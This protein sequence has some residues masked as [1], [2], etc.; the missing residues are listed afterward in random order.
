MGVSYYCCKSCGRSRYEE[1]VEYCQGCD[2]RICTD[3][4]VDNDGIKSQ[5]AYHYGI[6][7]D[8]TNEEALKQ[9]LADGWVTKNEDG[10]YDMAE[11]ELFSDTAIDPRYCPF[12]V[13]EDIDKEEC[14]NHLLKVFG[15]DIKQVWE[16]VKKAKN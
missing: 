12:C 15:L 4:V 1:Y 6:R 10:T 3:C 8:S 7:F 9:Q 13:G 2:N 16:E 11:G 14:L 5:Y